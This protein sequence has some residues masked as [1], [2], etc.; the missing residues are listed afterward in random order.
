MIRNLKALGLALIAIC[1]MGAV[2]ASA[3]SAVEFHSEKTSTA[4]SG[5]QVNVNKFTTDSGEI[6]C[7]KATFSGTTSA[8]NT[9][10]PTQTVTPSYSECHLIFIFTFNVTVD[11]NGCAYVLHANGEVDIECPTVEGKQKVIEVTA[12]SCTV[13]VPAQTGLKGVTY[14][15][16]GKGTGRTVTVNS[17][18]T[19]I[20]YE[21]HGSACEN[22]T[23]LTKNGTYT[24]SVKVSG[25]VGSE[26]V[27]IWVE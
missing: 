22:E 23:E 3:A 24:G 19:G 9:T 14:T 20:K 13:T 5:S 8:V 10:E 6:T 26:A 17:N 15:N 16:E 7:A 11:M 21:E 1:A 4:L 2:A 18:V 12:P 25:K 27:G